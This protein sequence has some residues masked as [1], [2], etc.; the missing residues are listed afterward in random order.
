MT[1]FEPIL[2]TLPSFTPSLALEVLPYGLTLHRVFVQ[3]GGRTHDIVIGPESPKDH[4]TQKYTNSIV[5]RYANRIPVGKHILERHGI[6]SELNALPN[7]NQRV[8]LHGGPVGYD[9]VPWTVLETAGQL[10]LFSDTEIA[11]LSEPAAQSSQAIFRLE[12]KDGDQGFP[13]KLLIEVVI[14]LVSP[15]VGAGEISANEHYDL[16]SIVI[17]YRA[18]LAEG[19][20][21]V[22]TPVNLTQHW[23]FNLDAS[24]KEG[25]NYLSVKDNVLTI[26]SDRITELNEVALATG[27][28]TPTPPGSDHAHVNKRIGDRFPEKGY[29]DYYVFRADAVPS[30]PSRLPLASFS[31]ETDFVTD[32]LKPVSE[33]TVTSR[34]GNRAQ[35]TV[36]L[37]SD[38][39]GLK[40]IFDSN[41][42]G[43]MFYSNN[44]STAA[45]GARK[46]IH[47]GSGVSGNGDAYS[48]GTAVF[49]EFH[50]P[51]TAFL[52]PAN[53]DGEDTL[54]TT[55]ELYH[56]YVR[57]DIKFKESRQ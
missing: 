46:K 48:P 12:S 29:D 39:S 57:L 30:V 33:D 38:K 49:L 15:G 24:L 26:K 2:L 22:V 3:A 19:D 21:K 9:A 28:Y 45:K 23:G 41:Q 53:K 13:G 14:A 47:G 27:N 51:I 54:L 32:L 37:T 6:T 34:G 20:K 35:P 31:A 40:L 44:L 18:K 10:K 7:E 17:I 55:E 16:G 36:E 8:S 56:N 50:N 1:E 4:V 25:D 42:R 5:G 52:E 11:R 43:V